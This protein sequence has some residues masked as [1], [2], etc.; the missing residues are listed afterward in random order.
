MYK[1][2]YF[3]YIDILD[4]SI[5]KM[6][7]IICNIEHIIAQILEVGMGRRKPFTLTQV[8]QGRG[9][10]W[11]V[12]FRDPQ[13]GKRM[14]KKSVE[15]LRKELGDQTQDAIESRREAEAICVRILEKRQ[16]REKPET[17]PVGKYLETFYDWGKSPYIQRRITLDSES[18]SKD[19][20]ATRHNLLSKHVVPIVPRTMMLEDVDIGFLEDL[21]YTLVKTSTLS[22]GTVNMAMQAVLFA[23]KEAQRR[24]KIPLRTPLSI[25]P[26]KVCHRMRGV[27]TDDETKAYFAYAKTVSNKRIYLSAL[28]SLFT[29]M[30]SGE[31]RGLT[32]GQVGNG[33]ITVDRAYAD[34]QGEKRPK[35]K[36]TRIVPCPVALCE[37]LCDFARTNPYRP[38]ETL[39]FW[40]PKKGGHV[41]SHYFCEIFHQT[42][43]RSEILSPEEVKRRNITF[44]SF[45]HMANSLLRGAVDEYVLRMTIGHT[46]EQL[47]DLYTHLSRKAF[48]SVVLAQEANIL[49]L[50]SDSSSQRK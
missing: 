9:V 29:G 22:K 41:S 4:F 40:S 39:V 33:M 8:K 2:F 24:G 48:D 49:P 18:L 47:S 11:Y 32:A 13:T 44:H 45:R 36:K 28:L 7:D 31:L 30:R 3:I 37:A 12:M 38:K 14:T 16:T 10:F 20:M 15:V 43:E 17:E 35:G 27:M 21:Q 42:L 6:Y 50:V 34:R 23:L 19:Y 5:L 1:Y 26:L 46:S 25:I